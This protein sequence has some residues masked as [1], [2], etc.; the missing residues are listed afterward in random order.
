MTQV[1]S[2]HLRLHCV[3]RVQLG[4]LRVVSVQR[5][6]PHSAACKR[7]IDYDDDQLDIRDR[8]LS[9]RAGPAGCPWLR[10]LLHLR[11]VLRAHGGLHAGHGA[12][13]AGRQHRRHRAAGA[14]VLSPHQ[15]QL[16]ADAA[17]A[18]TVAKMM[19]ISVA[20]RSVKQPHA[21]SCVSP[22]SV[23]SAR[24]A[25]RRAAQPETVAE[26]AQSPGREEEGEEPRTL[27]VGIRALAVL[28]LLLDQVRRRSLVVQPASSRLG[29]AGPS[30]GRLLVQPPAAAAAAAAAAVAAAHAARAARAARADIATGTAAGANVV[31]GRQRQRRRY[32]LCCAAQPVAGGQEEARHQHQ[33]H[34]WRSHEPA[35]AEFTAHHTQRLSAP[36]TDASGCLSEREGGSFGVKKF[37]RYSSTKSDSPILIFM[38]DF[39]KKRYQRILCDQ[40]F[41]VFLS[42]AGP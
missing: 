2:R 33:G 24:V 12:R 4:A 11:W 16:C 10:P 32:H 23:R 27:S 25:S 8:H 36:L 42:L 5:D 37:D 22:A 3:L 9:V 40:Y 35:A 34:G 6:F 30:R 20:C 17:F 7:R 28:V 29:A 26:P 13:D 38:S 39:D 1:C 41:A 19:C 21:R 14:L 18:L 31:A 15:G